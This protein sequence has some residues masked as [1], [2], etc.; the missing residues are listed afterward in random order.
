MSTMA[1]SLAFRVGGDASPIVGAMQQA[2]NAAKK[3]G[4]DAK[5]SWGSA[6]KALKT[7]AGSASDLVSS[8]SSLPPAISAM[9]GPLGAVG[10]G[11]AAIAG[12]GWKLAEANSKW[13]DDTILAADTL[14]ISTKTMIA[15]GAAMDAAGI[16]MEA[17]SAGIRAFTAKLGEAKSGSVS[18][19]K[20]FRDL[21][22]ETSGSVEESFLATIDAISKLPDSTTRATVA[23]DMLGSRGAKV[24][25][26]LKD[27][28]GSVEEWNK[29]A[30]YYGAV[31]GPEAIKASND[32]DA[33][34]GALKLSTTG[35]ASAWGV[36]FTPNVVA[37]VEVMAGAVKVVGDLA[38]EAQAVGTA[39][40]WMAVVP[41]LAGLAVDAFRDEEKSIEGVDYATRDLREST[42]ELG[43]SVVDEL[44][45]FTLR[46]EAR[47]RAEQS[48]RSGASEAK[49]AADNQARAAKEQATATAQLASIR[50]ASTLAV[51]DGE[52]KLN[53]EYRRELA[54]IIEIAKVSGDASA[55]QEAA[56][57]LQIKHEMDLADIRTENAKKRSDESE[58]AKKKEEDTA[59][60]LEAFEAS[61]ARAG[62]TRWEAERA[63]IEETRKA[64]E[65]L[66]ASL[67]TMDEIQRQ[68]TEVAI[69][70]GLEMAASVSSAM[71]SVGSILSMVSDKYAEQA[72]K[73]RESAEAQ[74]EAAGLSAEAQTAAGEA[75]AQAANEQAANA[76][77]RA[78]AF[79]YGS[80]VISTAAAVAR[81]WMDYPFP[82]SLLIAG[83]AATAGAVEIARI[84]STELSFSDTPR[85]QYMP[86]GGSVRLAPGDT[87]V[88]AK[89]PDELVR[90]ANRAAGRN[91]APAPVAIN[92]DG[93]KHVA[94]GR[95]SRDAARAPGAWKDIQ[96]QTGRS[97]GRL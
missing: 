47:K 62:L 70:H 69:E 93:Y 1:E 29:T 16:G 10:A 79:A 46:E 68:S 41:G 42:D 52:A 24:A 88:A 20:A 48:A 33:A 82:A 37:A 51:L 4:T 38:N 81:A 54:N 83:T 6:D 64:A 13:V 43:E 92:F 18:A 89:N 96:R 97:P 73:A 14:G 94:M 30:E 15:L 76:F 80:A 60:T 61:V 2:G 66:G 26:A 3:A 78:Q 72:A 40:K 45:M 35:A 84:A 23:I 44:E 63:Q 21:G 75:A 86:E 7:V 25:A 55:A 67:E 49:K 28:S 95:G 34:M 58:K 53:E 74:A 71:D 9:L 11:F 31:V 87:F 90:Q 65:K 91:T 57:A 77:E 50:D 19:Q 85:A 17:G 59:Q 56:I 5:Q 27:G 22:V 12:A 8:F 39:L 32:M 36:A